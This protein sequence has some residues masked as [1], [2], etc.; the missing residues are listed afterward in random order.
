MFK[1]QYT[2]LRGKAGAYLDP[3]GL[4][5]VAEEPVGAGGAL[6]SGGSLGPYVG[7]TTVR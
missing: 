7:K 1:I 2:I 4:M 3:G 5:E 6:C